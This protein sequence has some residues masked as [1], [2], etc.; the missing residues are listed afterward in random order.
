MPRYPARALDESSASVGGVAAVD[1]AL[2]VLMCFREGD[3][4]LSLAEIAERT[5]MAKSTV[6]RLLASL[7]HHG[8]AQRVDDRRYMLGPSVAWL[9]GIYIGSFSLEAAA[10]PALRQLMAATGES[11][12]FHVRQGDK[13]LTLFRVESPQPIRD[14]GRAGD[15]FPLERGSGGRVLLAFAGTKGAIYEKIR[16]EGYVALVGDRMPELAGISAP[17]FKAGGELVGAV[18]LTM[19][20]MRYTAKHIP[21]V[22][23]AAREISARLGGSQ[24]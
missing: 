2:A 24:P 12:A 1:R 23:A 19:P 9:Y 7:Q 11:T 5:K 13:R 22:R 20:A 21:A 17:V 14:H 4:S 10:L 16:R 8:L 3:G 6:L 15:I 18:T